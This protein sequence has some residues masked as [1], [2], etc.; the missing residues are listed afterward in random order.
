[1]NIRNNFGLLWI[2]AFCL[3]SCKDMARKNHGPI[4]LGDT[5][6]IV[7]EKDPQ[8]LQDLVRDLNP[9]IPSAVPVDTPKP[10]AKQTPA[11][12]A[13]KATVTA[14]QPAAPAPLPSGPGL[15]AEF[16]ELTVVIPNLAA[17]LSGSGNLQ[18]ANG[19]VYT[20][21]SGNIVGNVLHTTGN[22]TKVAQRYQSIV[23]LKTKSGNL[24]LE[25]LSETTPWQLVNGGNNAYPVSGLRDNE[26][27]YADTDAGDIKDAIS[28][29]CRTRHLSS[30]KK[31]E[32]LSALGNARTANQHPLFVTLRSVMWKIDG[33]DPSGK[34]FSKQIRID[35]PL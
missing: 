15:K 6:T 21:T 20:W 13:K 29:S 30:K 1:M 18:K 19:A 33:K 5:S 26:L 24:P 27:K 32:F 31:Q 10:V 11:D 25:E 28:K 16:K 23:I 17:K 7:T 35:I 9:V 12:T 4:R 2:G 14:A 34:I 8:K 3:F 22:V